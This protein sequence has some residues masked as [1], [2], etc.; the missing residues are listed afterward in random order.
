MKLKYRIGLQATASHGYT[1]PKIYMIFTACLK[2][3]FLKFMQIVSKR[4]LY[5]FKT[6]SVLKTKYW[7]IHFQS[8]NMSQQKQRTTHNNQIEQKTVLETGQVKIH[9]YARPHKE[10]LLTKHSNNYTKQK[11]SSSQT[12]QANKLSDVRAKT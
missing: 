1:L 3:K 2:K 5:Q 12:V 6:N 9:A 10:N 8:V 7:K 11:I 4:K